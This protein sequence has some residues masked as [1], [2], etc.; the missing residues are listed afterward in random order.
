M[1]KLL[2][3]AIAALFTACDGN[4][5]PAPSADSTRAKADS[6]I[7]FRP[8]KSPFPVVYSSSF[9]I[10]DP[11]YAE[12]VLALW[13]DYENGDIASSKDLIADSIELY[14]SDGSAFKLSRD[15]AIALVQRERSAMKS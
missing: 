6:G 7:A 8:I 4:N 12:A 11:K 5:S 9:T 13:K 15:S 3:V 1:K 2:I 14:P 10:D